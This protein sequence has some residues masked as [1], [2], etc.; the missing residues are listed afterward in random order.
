M[1]L[2]LVSGI[3][4]GLIPAIQGSRLDLVSAIKS[5][6]KAPVR[7]GRWTLGLDLR[8][9]LVTC[10]V[11]VSLVA[12]IGAGLFG[13]TQAVQLR[14]GEQSLHALLLA[15]A[16]LLLWVAF[17]QFRRKATYQAIGSV[18]AAGLALLWY[19]TTD[20]V[21]REF[22]GMAPYVAT[23]LVLALASQQLRM[24]AADGQIYRKGSAG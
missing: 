21:P 1:A 19:F 8:D 24:P 2:S 12:L 18:V 16:V 13:Y 4:F 3:L 23:L 17:T 20:E 6:I 7:G 5:Q 22:T 14:N 15:I 9:V 11:A 10:Q